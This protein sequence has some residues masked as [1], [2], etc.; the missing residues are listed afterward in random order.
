MKY[1]NDFYVSAVRIGKQAPRFIMDAISPKGTKSEFILDHQLDQ[2]KWVVLYFYGLDFTDH[3]KK[4]IEAFS[5]LNEDFDRQNALLVA[6]STDSI[7]AHERFLKASLGTVNHTLASDMT[8]KV[9]EAFGVLNE[10]LGY[11][12]K[13]VFMIAPNGILKS[14][15]TVDDAV[16]IDPKTVLT[17]LKEIKKQN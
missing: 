6:V 11:A 3:A 9:S 4:L 17:L 7:H 13:G 16:M 14:M 5:L 10:S 2:G 12:H 1:E 8:H 15:Q